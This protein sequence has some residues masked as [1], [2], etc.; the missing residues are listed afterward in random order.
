MTLDEY[1]ESLRGVSV[2][3]VGLGVSN[4]PLL[5]LL[6]DHGAAVTVRDRRDRDKFGKSEADEL[7]DRGCRL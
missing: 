5:R 4:R 7:E 2:A 3:V 6:M 1:M